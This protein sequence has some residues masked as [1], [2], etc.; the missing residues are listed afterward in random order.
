MRI[1]LVGH[2]RMGRMVEG[3]APEFGCEV[4]G[5]LEIDDAA[6]LDSLAAGWGAVDVAIDFSYPDA[7]PVNVPALASRGINIV[8]GTTGWSSREA[9]V[10]K[11]AEA[12]GIGV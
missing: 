3:L 12:A 9:D 1:V 6:R 4:A 5:I 8:I 11:A 2:G 7:V 10:R